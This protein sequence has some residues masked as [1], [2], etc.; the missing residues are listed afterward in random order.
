MEFLKVLSSDLSLGSCDGQQTIAQAKDVFTY[1]DSDFGNWGLNRASESAKEM[2]VKVYEMKKD[3]TFNQMFNDINSDLNKLCL[4][5]GQIIEFVQKYREHLR[6]NGYATFF[7]FK[8]GR[9]F[10]VARVY[11]GSSDLE[12]D[13]SRFESVCAW[14]A[15]C[16]RRLVAPQLP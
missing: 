11:V 8:R 10:F 9:K 5:Q 6:P 16:R 12:V 15:G 7:L 14:R 2:K 1:R 3:A 4:F 13:V